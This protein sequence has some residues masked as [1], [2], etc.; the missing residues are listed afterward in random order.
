MNTQPQPPRKP[1][2]DALFERIETEKVG[3]RS[4]LFFQGRECGVW[5]LWFLSVLVGSLAV[6][7]TLFV[8]TH[9]QYEIY[10]ATHENF[11]TFLVE[12]LPY[13][14]IIVF[15]LMVYV[16]MYNL[17]HTK[18]GYR[19]PVWMIVTSSVALSFV[20][21]LSLQIF[22]LGYSV[23][24]ILGHQMPMYISRDKLEQR[25]WQVP[26]EGRLVGRQ[27]LATMSPTSTIVFEDSIGQRWNMDVSELRERDI[28]LLASEQTVRL[29]GKS[30][31]TGLKLFHACGAFP[32]MNGREVTMDEMLKERQSFIE[33]VY[34]Y[35]NKADEHTALLDGEVFASTSLPRRSIC[36]D[37][38]AV[39][40]MPVARQ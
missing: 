17:Q 35:A 38:T 22:G 4:K 12:A 2:K 9:I 20:G 30:R 19:Y 27:V 34:G 16:A 3:P 36:K 25:L 32:L 33:N 1:L 10:E 40:R 13:L 7:V 24:R 18:N 6:A 23:D 31:D 8:V 37:I 15:G 29:L 39:R 26:E 21:G 5:F 11:F 28:K 14:W